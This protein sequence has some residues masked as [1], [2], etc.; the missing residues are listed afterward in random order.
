MYE[1]WHPL[2][3]VGIITAFNF[4]WR[5]GL[6]R[7]HRRDLWKR[8][9]MET[10]TKNAALWCRGAEHLQ[11]RSRRMDSHQFSCSSMTP[12]L[13]SRH[14]RRGSVDLVSFTGSSAIG[15]KSRRRRRASRK[16]PLA[17]VAITRSSW[18]SQPTLDSPYR[19]SCSARSARRVSGTTT[20]RLFIHNCYE[21]FATLVAAYAQVR[22]GVR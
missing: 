3:V 6:E 13:I 1:Q 7:V 15:R 18:M 2:G 14:V 5:C 19:A 17:S 22:I 20:R 10:I 9:R 16:M 12:G 21:E 8:Q 4:P 11:R